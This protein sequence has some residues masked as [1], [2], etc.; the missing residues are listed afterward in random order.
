M[1]NYL[2]K[3]LLKIARLPR[4]DQTWIIR[5]LNAEQLACFKNKHGDNLL[6]MAGR[7]KL[8]KSIPETQVATP[9][10]PAE[11]STLGHQPSLYTAIILDQGQFSWQEQFLEQHDLSKA[12]QQALTD[13]VSSIKPL[14]KKAVFEEWHLANRFEALLENHHG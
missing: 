2:K 6:T 1:D 8:I 12:I 4:A 13:Q 14:V 5:Q 9:V 10:L 3:I 11:C 7:F